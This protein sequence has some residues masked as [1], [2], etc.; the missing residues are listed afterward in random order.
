MI[1][2]EEYL[3][4]KN[5]KNRIQVVLLQIDRHPISKIFSIY[6][7]LFQYDGKKR[8]NP[9]HLSSMELRDDLLARKLE[10]VLIS[11]KRYI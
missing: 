2:R 10:K 1:I 5:N 7:T 3:V 11:I 4:K 9:I 6:R 8:E